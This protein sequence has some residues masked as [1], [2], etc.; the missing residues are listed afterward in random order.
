MNRHT[1]VAVIIVNYNGGE[2]VLR[3]LE[4]LR[5]QTLRPHRILLVDN[6]SRDHSLAVIEGTFPEVETIPATKNLGFAAANNLA[7]QK[8]GDCRWVAL[9]NP[10]AFPEPT[11]LENLVKATER[12]PQHSF[13]GSTQLR[14]GACD[15]LDGTGDVYHVSGMSWQRDFGLPASKNMRGFD[16]IFS[17]CAAAALYLREAFLQAG[18]FDEA[19]FLQ[20]EDVDLGF[21]L[22]LLGYR[23]LHVPDAI[24]HHM[25]SAVLGKN[26]ESADY[27]VH[28]NMVWTF[29]KNM[30]G[31]LL[32]KYLP[33]HILVNLSMLLSFCLKG[34]ALILLRAKWDAVKGLSRVL[35]QRRHIQQNRAVEI[36]NLTAL[37]PQGWL[38]PFSGKKK[39][40]VW[41]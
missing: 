6:A 13:F 39:F 7:V 24:V 22:R 35:K 29:I 12:F 15:E 31:P 18:G 26:S 28:R 1:R 41:E 36:E 20:L 27:Y 9:L 30:P 17:P 19:F 2:I 25:G 21:R 14:Y 32:W 37:M 5:K 33:Q 16:E 8:A 4:A 34:R 40:S 10:D 23:C 3:C 38:L 11:W